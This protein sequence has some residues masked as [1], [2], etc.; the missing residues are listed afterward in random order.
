M[1]VHVSLS[2]CKFVTIN[3]AVL[4]IRYEK[5]TPQEADEKSAVSL[6]WIDWIIM[7]YC[8]NLYK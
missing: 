6:G 2:P 3:K 1:D 8:V 7:C 4:L 5:L